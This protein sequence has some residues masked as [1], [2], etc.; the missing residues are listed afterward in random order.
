MPAYNVAGILPETIQEL[1]KN[2]ADEV[3]VVDDGSSDGTADVARK[4]GLTVVSHVKNRGYGGAQKT[5]YQ[6]AI[7][8]DA[9]IAVMVHGDNQYDPSFALKFISKIRDE[10]YDVVTGTRMILGDA[11]RGGMPIWK[12]IPNR[13]LTWLENLQYLISFPL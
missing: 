9:D 6:E 13:F 12:Y 10:G 3:I 4:L 1:P 11:L 2:S 8:R 7:R 5:G